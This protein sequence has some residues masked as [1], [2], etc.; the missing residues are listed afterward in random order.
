MTPPEEEFNLLNQLLLS[1]LAPDDGQ[2]MCTDTQLEQ[3]KM[4]SE[5]LS[6]CIGLE[7]IKR[8]SAGN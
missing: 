4:A 5:D 3:V 2:S 6:Q 7:S 8:V 1:L